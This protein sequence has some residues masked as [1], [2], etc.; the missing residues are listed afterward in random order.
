MYLNMFLH[1]SC[2]ITFM[3]LK[4]DLEGNSMIR[5][6][7]FGEGKTETLRFSTLGGGVKKT[8]ICVS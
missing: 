4:L 5:Y 8:K 1:L 3:M 6:I 7:T 2:M